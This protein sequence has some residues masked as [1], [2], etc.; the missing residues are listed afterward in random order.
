MAPALGVLVAT[1]RADAK[2]AASNPAP[3]VI[4][5]AEAWRRLTGAGFGLRQSCLLGSLTVRAIAPGECARLEAAIATMGGDVPLKPEPGPADPVRRLLAAALRWSIAIQRQAM[6]PVSSQA[7]IG[8]AAVGA[9]GARTYRVAVDGYDFRAAQQVLDWVLQAIS[10]LAASQEPVPGLAGEMELLVARL[11][12]AAGAGLNQFHLIRAANELEIP[13]RDLAPGLIGL[14]SG[15]HLRMLSETITDATPNIGVGVA[16]NKVAAAT[17]LRRAGLPAAAHVRVGSEQ[18]ALRAAEVLKYPVVVKP[19][20]LDQGVGVAAGLRDERALREAYRQ[21]RRQ[22][23]DILVEKHYEGQDYRLTVFG[24]Q[25]VKIMQRVAGSVTGDGRSSIAA[26]VGQAQQSPRMRKFMRTHGKLPLALDEE[27]L[28]LLRERGLGPDSVPAAGA[29]IILRRQANISTGGEQLGIPLE[30]A[31]ADNLAL[32]VRAAQQLRLDVAGVDLIAPDIATSWQKSEAI[33]CEVNAQPQIGT[34]NSPE[35]Y[36]QLIRELVGEEHRIPCHLVVTGNSQGPSPAEAAALA[37][38]LG[39]NAW[40]G[41]DGVWIDGERIAAQP[42]DAFHAAL[43]LSEER[44]ARAMLGIVPATA[45][46]KAGLPADWIDTLR[47]WDAS[48][49]PAWKSID[50]DLLLELIGPHLIAPDALQIPAV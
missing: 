24:D 50:L 14:G 36:Q 45:I 8:N 19:G 11:G 17:L 29:M 3:L 48:R 30:Q 41:K 37:S 49:K 4:A 7:H 43:I 46:L 1:R 13:V 28:G 23:A 10:V 35:I 5:P 40:S 2:L 38:E 44:E 31:H 16:R 22:S 25:V 26:L 27:A 9:G 18:E 34:R 42:L 39:C 47:F 32:A 21:A 6:L 20:D 15:M 33:I 12:A